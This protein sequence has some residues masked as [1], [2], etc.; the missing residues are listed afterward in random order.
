MAT[1]GPCL[2][3]RHR[4]KRALYPLT[5]KKSRPVTSTMLED[6]LLLFEPSEEHGEE[7]MKPTSGG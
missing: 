1:D 4:H 3:H 6:Q 2:A 5:I 7:V